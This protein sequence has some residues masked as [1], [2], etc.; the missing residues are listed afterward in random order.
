MESTKKISTI[1]LA[2]IVGLFAVSWIVKSII[3]SGGGSGL[4]FS[5]R[6]GFLITFAA[7][8]TLAIFS[9]LYKD[10]P[11]YKFAEH[12]FVGVSAAYW[13]CVGF[14]ST[15]V[16]N[17]FP[18]LSEE[19]ST[20]FGQP[21]RGLNVF[22]IIP[23][24][25]GVLL[26]MRISSKAGWISR[27]SLAWIVGTTAG[28]NLVNYLRTDF[29]SQVSN[30]FIPVLVDW[31][32]VDPFISDFSLSASGQFAMTLSNWVVIIGVF[33]G[34]IYFFFSKEHKGFF[35][36]A[37]KV[38]IWVLMITFGASFGYTVMG[39]VSLLVG[40]LTYLYRDWLGLIN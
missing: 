28:L 12:L 32:G 36:A 40:R 34:L 19:L 16:G 35:G 27:W 14:Y 29:I 24:V 15:V 8:L 33:C 20:F 23:L 18:N 26:L 3:L 10:N 2:V 31:K 21:Y 38:G 9:F 6:D 39:R 1:I 13:M 7:F 17:L 25:L 22:Y 11:Y 4:W 30:T 5:V 37:S